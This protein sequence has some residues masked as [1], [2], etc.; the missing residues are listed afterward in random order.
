MCI[1]GYCN[2]DVKGRWKFLGYDIKKGG[3][4][5]LLYKDVFC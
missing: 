3:G 1:C 2:Y 4:F 5:F